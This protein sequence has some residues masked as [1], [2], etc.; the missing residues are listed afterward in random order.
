[1]ATIAGGYCWLI[2]L[3][4]LNSAGVDEIPRANYYVISACYMCPMFFWM[5]WHLNLLNSQYFITSN[6]LQVNG[7]K[8]HFTFQ[9]LFG[10][11]CS[12]VVEVVISAILLSLKQDIFYNWVYKVLIRLTPFIA[13]T[14]T[15]AH[16]RTSLIKIVSQHAHNEKNEKGGDNHFKF[17]SRWL[18]S[19]WSLFFSLTYTHTHSLTLPHSLFLFIGYPHSLSVY[20]CCVLSYTSIVVLPYTA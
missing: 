17:D 2:A 13:I 20:K 1:M 5:T 6:G 9:I 4:P 14:V 15:S 18:H 16:A 11:L 8:S 10:T 12:V 19:L 7:L 3:A